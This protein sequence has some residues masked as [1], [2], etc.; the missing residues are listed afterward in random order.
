MTNITTD[1][2]AI[3]SLTYDNERI[4]D[5]IWRQLGG[6]RFDA[7]AGAEHH[8]ASHRCLRFAVPRGVITI[9]L[10]PS[11]TYTVRRL[12]PTGVEMDRATDVYCEQL[13]EVVGRMLGL[14]VSL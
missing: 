10:E 14:A 6:R 7:M 3:E 11:D 13:A 4:A 5:T 2:H 12:S 9:H 8:I 1:M